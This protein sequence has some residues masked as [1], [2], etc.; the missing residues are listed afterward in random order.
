MKTTQDQNTSSVV[1]RE[2]PSSGLL[3]TSKEAL[4]LSAMSQLAEQFASRPDFNRLVELMLLTISGQFAVTDAFVHV[5]LGY[6]AGDRPGVYVGCGKFRNDAELG[7]MV[8]DDAG[9]L[10]QA[11]EYARL[12]EL[13][14]GDQE[15]VEQ[16]RGRGI[17]IM[18]PLRDNQ[19][20]IGAIGLGSKV[21]R[22]PLDDSDIDL[23]LWLVRSLTPLLVNANLFAEIDT[24]KSWYADILN[25]IKQ[26]IFV[27]DDEFRLKM[28]NISALGLLEGVRHCPIMTDEQRVLPVEEIFP[29]REF[30][31]WAE[32]LRRLPHDQGGSL[33]QPML[34]ATPDRERV[35][36]AR[37]THSANLHG[38]DNDI[39]LSL[40]DITEQKDSENRM[41]NLERLAEKGTMASS[42]AH[43]LNNYLGMVLGGIEMAQL[44]F[45]DDKPEKGE[46]YLDKTKE[47][48]VKMQ[49]FTAG[50]I[51][52]HR[53]DPQPRQA[54]LADV[55][56]DVLS[57]VQVQKKFRNVRIDCN[58]SPD[59]PMLEIDVDQIAQLLLNLL[60]NAVDTICE[61]ERRHGR[62]EVSATAKLDSVILSVTDNGQGIPP[63][64]QERLFHEHLTTKEGGHGYGLVTCAKI[65]KN[66]RATVKIDS[67]IGHGSTFIVTFP[68]H[69]PDAS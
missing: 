26:S 57:F 17:S 31:S 32:R 65:L 53:L 37:V 28:M 43:E 19:R 6:K 35:F 41:F 66:H 30:P 12:T 69:K 7:A 9:G 67:E 2:T 39:I 33:N 27:F 51:G 64:I 58:L 3:T 45:L 10:L 54:Q 48:I 8:R 47:H 44:N 49:R 38:A 13:S 20:I 36:N 11:K 22:K 23:L 59:I 16:F 21:T 42:I 55:V 52:Q 46:S 15:V 4:A 68:T 18:V 61:T 40:D 62:I 29:A 56:N 34:A 60:N 5:E 63:D 24:L 50:L 1:A 25:N 14:E